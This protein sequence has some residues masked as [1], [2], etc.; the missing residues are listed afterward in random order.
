M[1]GPCNVYFIAYGWLKYTGIFITTSKFSLRL[2][3]LILVENFR[4]TCSYLHS[5]NLII[6]AFTNSSIVIVSKYVYMTTDLYIR[7]YLYNFGLSSFSFC[8]IY[9]AG[10][11]NIYFLLSFP[12]LQ[13][14]FIWCIMSELQYV[15]RMFIKFW[16]IQT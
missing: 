3:V 6:S 4:L 1:R 7:L 15:L 10:V 16:H 11:E 2:D 8:L 12:F 9:I 13:P 5:E 14:G